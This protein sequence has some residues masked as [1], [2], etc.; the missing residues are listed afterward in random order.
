[1]WTTMTSSRHVPH[2]TTSLPWGVPLPEGRALSTA[3]HRPVS[4]RV[5]GCPSHVRWWQRSNRSSDPD[6]RPDRPY[7]VSCSARRRARPMLNRGPHSQRQSGDVS[8]ETLPT[9]HLLPGPSSSLST[10]AGCSVSGGTDHADHNRNGSP[11]PKHRNRQRLRSAALVPPPTAPSAHRSAIGPMHRTAARSAQSLQRTAVSVFEP[12]SRRDQ[13][14]RPRTQLGSM[15]YLPPAVS[16]LHADLPVFHV[17][18]PPRESTALRTSHAPQVRS[19]ST[20]A[21]LKASVRPSGSTH[22]RSD[23]RP[24]A[25]MLGPSVSA[26]SDNHLMHSPHAPLGPPRR[27]RLAHV[28]STAPTR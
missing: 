19:T 12:C 22:V 24:R 18:Q 10:Y 25:R 1:M 5:G 14:W 15:P 8:R 9:P 21:L 2:G 13:V 3:P 11:T 26:R 23:A 20:E 6:A 27:R 17:K 16:G 28:R 4:V 7:R